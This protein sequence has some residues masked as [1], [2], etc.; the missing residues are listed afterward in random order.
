MLEVRFYEEIEDRL[1]KYAVIC[2][3]SNKQ[4][5]FCKH[6][7][8]ITYELPGGHREPGEDILVTAD[9]ELR[10]ETGACNFE[11][12]PV[13][14]YSVRNKEE[15]IDHEETFGLLCFAE[16]TSFGALPDYEMEQV[17]LREEMPFE[18]TYPLIQPK[19]IERVKRYLEAY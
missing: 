18:Q 3:R 11:L 12:Q 10:E 8:R 19:L 7:E 15:G 2:A 5:V 13:T 1:L 6:K 17:I 14:I 4:W 9:R 16:I